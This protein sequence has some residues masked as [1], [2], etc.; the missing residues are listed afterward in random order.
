LVKRFLVVATGGA[1][2]DLQPLIAAALAIRARGHQ[3][4]FVGDRSVGRALSGLGVDAQVL[5]AELDLG[6][7]LAGAIRDAMAATGGDLVAAGPLVEEQLARWAQEA[8]LPISKAV[9]DL[10]PDTV[11]TSLFGVEVVQRAPRRAPGPSSTAPST[12]VRT[13][14][15]RSRTTSEHGPFP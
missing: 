1:G 13:R 2:G 9:A 10:R 8:A 3:A 4:M 6:P 15:G 14:P 11:V 12:W 5:P 7:R